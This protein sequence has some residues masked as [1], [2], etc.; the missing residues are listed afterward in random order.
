MCGDKY[1][2][3][4][5]LPVDFRSKPA[6][7]IIDCYEKTVLKAARAWFEHDSWRIVMYLLVILLIDMLYEECIASTIQPLY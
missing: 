1:L 2:R 5:C 3:R 4:V 6:L 7:S